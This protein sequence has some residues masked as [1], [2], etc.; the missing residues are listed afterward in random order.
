MPRRPGALSP[1]VDVSF[2]EDSLVSTNV[3]SNT[4]GIVRTQ[5]EA[6]TGAKKCHACAC[7]HSTIA[8][9]AGSAL[10]SVLQETLARA[11]ETVQPEEYDCR[12]CP[13]C[14]PAIATNAVSEA[15]PEQVESL[16]VCP[17]DEPIE[18]RGWPPLPGTYTVLRYRAPVAVCTLNSE[19]LADQLASQDP[20]GLA[21]AGTMRT[22][23]LGIERLIR[24]VLGN[25]YI[26]FI[27]LCGEDT[28]QAI[29]HLPGQSLASLCAN[30]IDE[31]GRIRGAQ[32]KRSVLKNLS[33]EQIGT[34]LGQVELVN[35][36]GVI[37]KQELSDCI[38]TCR[39][40]DP[41]PFDS[42]L[43][44]NDLAPVQADEP[45]RLVLDRAGFFVV[46]P[47]PTREAL[48]VEHY[49]DDGV[50]DCIIEGR[51]PAAV[52]A[53]VIERELLTRLD[54]AAYL[55]RE[56]ALAER[57]MQTGESYVQDRAPGVADD[58]GESD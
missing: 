30:G 13:V 16:E 23:N 12:G 34:F 4:L 47:D 54:H 10:A 46:Y 26:R 29:G 58:S 14:F 31:S 11:K 49:T 44:E 50:L 35:R 41:G 15:F 57:S 33:G 20:P 56:L 53:T 22:E 52:Y 7:F 8:A 5:L 18:R 27:I 3:R 42:A 48:V 17:T 24:N 45:G 21:L 28:Q 37:D 25:P 9:L 19:E 40:R 36:I 6:A 51:T 55:G 43:R 2:V 1:D 38:E 39:E 32:G